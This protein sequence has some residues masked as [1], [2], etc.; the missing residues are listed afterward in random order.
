MSTDLATFSRITALIRRERVVLDGIVDPA[1]MAAAEKRLAA[2]A[3]LA[4]R[5]DLA[6]PIQNEATLLRAEARAG[7]A[8][9]IDA[10]EKHKGAAKQRGA[11]SAPRYKDLGVT[12]ERVSEGRAIAETGVLEEMKDRVKKNPKK[13][14]TM[15]SILKAAKSTQKKKDRVAK[16]RQEAAARAAAVESLPEHNFYPCSCAQLVEKV[17]AGS[18]GVVITDP[19]YSQKFLSTY[20][21]LSAF[22]THALKDGGLCVALA[23]QSYLPEVLTRLGEHLTYHWLGAYLMP[24][25]QSSGNR[26]RGVNAFWK[27]VCIFVKGRFTGSFGDVVK[28]DPNDNDAGF[29]HPWGQSESGSLDLVRRFSKPGDLVA[30]P[31]LGSGAIVLAALGEGRRAVGG[32]KDEQWVKK[33]EARING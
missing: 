31:F 2:I 11:E 12:S 1:E 25:G 13:P 32:D 20:S 28:S 24:G 27:P 26:A 29:I 16:E 7:L 6:V 8:R 23:G 17:T 10:G 18:V 5:A 30:D 4:K 33:T 9:L 22:A 15:D 14:I 21:E 19:P 3:D